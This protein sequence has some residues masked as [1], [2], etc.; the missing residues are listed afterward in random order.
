MK[1]IVIALV[2]L[3]CLLAG[4][5]L[6]ALAETDA[7][8][9]AVA[10]RPRAEE[11]TSEEDELP[12]AP[13]ATRQPKAAEE[14][15]AAQAKP[16]VA[17]EPENPRAPRKPQA[18]EKP[19]VTQEGPDA[20]G[21]PVAPK[22]G[23]EPAGPQEDPDAGDKPAAPK[24]N[25]RP[26]AA[27]KPDGPETPKPPKRHGHPG[28]VHPHRERHHGGEGAQT[29]PN[30][31]MPRR[32]GADRC[33]WNAAPHCRRCEPERMQPHCPGCPFAYED[34]GCCRGETAEP[35]PDL[36]PEQEP[37]QA[38]E[39]GKKMVLLLGPQTTI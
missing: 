2:V 28:A 3:V 39:P 25:R 15:D 37:R 1:K 10:D 16:D 38:E 36:P 9:P 13:K 8:H 32:F 7:A 30:E 18:V 23:E 31:R 19:D 29:G 27:E 22:A 14:P 26:K 34:P 11:K 20:D 5:L 6:P 24:A 35:L 4:A 21:E 12:A 33:P 17:D